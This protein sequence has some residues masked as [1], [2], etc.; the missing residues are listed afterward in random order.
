M[1]GENP[2]IAPVAVEKPVQKY[3]IT[4]LPMNVTVEVD[5]AHVPY[6]RT[7][8]PGSIL[9]IALAHGIDLEHSCG[10]VC[11]CSTCHIIVREG[12]DTLPEAGD[13]EEDMLDSAPS[14]ERWSRLA[15]QSVPPGTRNLIVEVPQWN[16]NAVQ[17]TPHEA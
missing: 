7:G 2:Y 6:G 17:E 9:D 4:F 13:E 8:R 14:L 16:R 15:C 5:P 11:A 10:G 3:T 1:A 12:F